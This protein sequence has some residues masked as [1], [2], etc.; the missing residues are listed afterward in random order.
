M[1]TSSREW[2]QEH[3]GSRKGPSHRGITQ[4]A[5]QKEACGRQQ[6]RNALVKHRR[7]SSM[8]W[9]LCGE[10]N[11]CCRKA[12]WRRRDSNWAVAWGND[13]C[14][15]RVIDNQKACDKIW[16][17]VE[18]YR[19]QSEWSCKFRR[20]GGCGR[21]GSW[22]RWYRAGQAERRWWTRQGDGHNLKNSSAPHGEV[23]AEAEDA[24]WIHT[25]GM[26]GCSQHRN[27]KG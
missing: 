22:S 21:W 2:M 23:L 1:T 6:M 26:G 7:E 4:L 14:W 12:S 27:W 9:G 11:H 3:P 5:I 17:D 10:R 16:G 18:C 24:W 8:D 25:I 13:K 15:K 19:R 20:W